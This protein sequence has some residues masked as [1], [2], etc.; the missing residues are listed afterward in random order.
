MFPHED[1]LGIYWVEHDD[2]GT[3]IR[4][5]PL[6]AGWPAAVRQLRTDLHTAITDAEHASDEHEHDEFIAAARQLLADLERGTAAAQR[7][8]DGTFAGRFSRIVPA[9]PPVSDPIVARL[10]WLLVRDADG[11]ATV[12]VT[13]RSGHQLAG[14]VEW[15]A[16]DDEVVWVTTTR[17]THVVRAVQIESFTFDRHE[18]CPA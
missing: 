2:D 13:T 9:G 10:R 18:R 12:T 5:S 6:A 3:W 1:D 15:D 11:L 17:L 7:P 8:F 14:Q 16:I 4:P